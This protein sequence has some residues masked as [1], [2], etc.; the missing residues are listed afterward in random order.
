MERLRDSGARSER[1]HANAESS[2]HLVGAGSGL[3]VPVLQGEKDLSGFVDRKLGD[4]ALG[5]VDR[6][7]AGL[8]VLAILRHLVD[9]DAPALAV[10]SLDFALLA[11][12]TLF[13]AA[14]LD[15]HGVALANGDGAA[16]VLI[17]EFLRQV[18]AHEL[19]PHVGRGTEVRFSRLSPLTG[20]G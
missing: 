20:H 1:V 5:R 11:L 14:R 16:L 18:A 6:Q 10:D 15:E 17:L 13:R 3:V 2:I 7:V 8:T 9:V 19:A 12:A 4:L